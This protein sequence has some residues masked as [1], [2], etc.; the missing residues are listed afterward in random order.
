MDQRKFVVDA[1]LPKGNIFDESKKDKDA[2]K[3]T[4]I[5]IDAKV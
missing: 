3:I 5:V 1:K 2:G 4:L